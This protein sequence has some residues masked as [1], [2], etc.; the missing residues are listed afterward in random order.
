MQQLPDKHSPCMVLNA[1]HMCDLLKLQEAKAHESNAF[2]EPLHLAAGS[3]LRLR[4]LTRVL[5]GALLAW[6]LALQVCQVD[7]EACLLIMFVH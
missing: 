5:G 7:C 2:A 4:H 6:C 3:T 1:V